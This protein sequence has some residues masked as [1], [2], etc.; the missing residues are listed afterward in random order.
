M[1]TNG[2]VE[3]QF[4]EKKFG[5]HPKYFSLIEIFFQKEFYVFYFEN[6]SGSLT[7]NFAQQI[8]YNHI[9][10]YKNGRKFPKNTFM[11]LRWRRRF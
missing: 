2:P 5:F 8:V 7:F 9:S 6:V 3:A 1:D 10:C 4:V 11:V